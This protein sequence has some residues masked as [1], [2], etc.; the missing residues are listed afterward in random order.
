[1]TFVHFGSFFSFSMACTI[2][3]VK[4]ARKK[5]NQ[6]LI[7]SS[8][9]RKCP[10]CRVND[11]TR[12][13]FDCNVTETYRVCWRSL[14]AVWSKLMLETVGSVN[15]FLAWCND[16]EFSVIKLQEIVGWFCGTVSVPWNTLKTL[17]MYFWSFLPFR[18]FVTRWQCRH[19][20]MVQDFATHPTRLTFPSSILYTPSPLVLNTFA[21][22]QL[23]YR[24][25]TLYIL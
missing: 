12:F 19:H 18:N 25:E 16:N 7:R 23:E 17:L 15:R 2:R 5:L 24:A 8:L 14:P 13:T 1:M 21:A 10:R 20:R 9:N 4:S 6:E 11:I 22:L 3:Q